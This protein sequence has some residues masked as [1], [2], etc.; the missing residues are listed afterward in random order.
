MVSVIADRTFCVWIVEE[1]FDNI[2]MLCA[3]EWITTNAD[4]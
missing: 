2:D 3:R 1:H 4:T